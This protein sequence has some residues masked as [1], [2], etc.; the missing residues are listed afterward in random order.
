MRRRAGKR[1]LVLISQVGSGAI[2][3]QHCA[4][5]MLFCKLSQGG[6]QALD[7]EKTFMVLSL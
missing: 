2:L 5:V 3:T 4:C 1:V 6:K 7:E